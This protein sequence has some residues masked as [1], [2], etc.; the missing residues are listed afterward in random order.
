MRNKRICHVFQVFV[1]M[2]TKTN[3]AMDTE[4]FGKSSICILQTLLLNIVSLSTPVT[5]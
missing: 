3:I 4:Y 1:T 2:V 5:V